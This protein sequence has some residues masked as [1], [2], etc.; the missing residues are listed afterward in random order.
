[1]IKLMN[2]LCELILNCLTRLEPCIEKCGKRVANSAER[3]TSQWQKERKN[4][5][6]RKKVSK[7]DGSNEYSNMKSKA[8]TGSQS[9]DKQTRLYFHENDWLSQ[10][11]ATSGQIW[12]FYQM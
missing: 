1:M 4:D 6:E 12:T 10:V 5:E 8:K 3:K 2:Y 7:I 11:Q 9:M